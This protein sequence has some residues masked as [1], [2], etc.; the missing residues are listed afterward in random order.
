MY[1]V[2]T[3]VAEEIGVFTTHSRDFW[4]LEEGKF[5]QESARLDI[6]LGEL[7]LTGSI[8]IHYRTKSKAKALRHAQM[9]G[10]LKQ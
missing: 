10:L 6:S 8:S 3:N 1:L 9:I 7:A 4:I 2:V 5:H